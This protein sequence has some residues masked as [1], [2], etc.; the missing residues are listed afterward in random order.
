MYAKWTPGPWAIPGQ[1]DKVCA[2]GFTRNGAA[3]VIATVHTP[4]WMASAEPWSN[5]HLIAAAPDLYAALDAF[6]MFYPMGINPDL[7]DAYRAARAAL[8]KARGE[9]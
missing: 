9:A 2:E 3:K 4:S 6:Q 1:P 8:V 7:D 5:A